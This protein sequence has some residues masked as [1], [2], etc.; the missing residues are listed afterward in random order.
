MFAM[1]CHKRVQVWVKK[2]IPLKMNFS[3]D[4]LTSALS[5]IWNQKDHNLP[6]IDVQ[7]I[8][9][10]QYWE[11]VMNLCFPHWCGLDPLQ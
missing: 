2:M 1:V 5:H 3:L 9:P 8:V 6:R 7:S 10:L 11:L 4:D